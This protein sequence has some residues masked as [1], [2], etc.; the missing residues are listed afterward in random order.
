MHFVIYASSNYGEGLHKVTPID[1]LAQSAVLSDGMVVSVLHKAIPLLWRGGRRS[2]TGWFFAY[3]P[4][5]TSLSLSDPHTHV[6]V[7]HNVTPID[8]LV[9]SAIQYALPKVPFCTNRT[10]CATWFWFP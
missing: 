10:A 2:L 6:M 8:L 3:P 4:I 9:Q 1:L 5:R 7:L